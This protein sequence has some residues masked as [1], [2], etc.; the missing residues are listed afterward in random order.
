LIINPSKLGNGSQSIRDAQRIQTGKNKPT[1]IYLHK[2]ITPYKIKYYE[3][4][5]YKN[6]ERFYG[7]MRIRNTTVEATVEK[8]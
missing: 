8:L 6:R 4:E 5:Q 1:N 7:Y 3:N 2:N